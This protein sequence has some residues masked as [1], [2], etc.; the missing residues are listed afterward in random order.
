M[1]PYIQKCQKFSN[2]KFAFCRNHGKLYLKI[3][4][5]NFQI[6]C[7]KCIEEGKISEI[8]IKNNLN[9]DEQINFNCFQHPNKKGSF[10]CDDCKEFICKKCFADFHKEHKCHLPEIIKNEFISYIN[11]EINNTNNLRP[12]L[13]DSINDIKKIHGNLKNRK[14]IL[15]NKNNKFELCGFHKKSIELLKEINNFIISSKNFINI[16]LNDTILKYNENHEKIENSLNSMSKDISKFE[17][18]CFLQ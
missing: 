3:N 11:E 12:M 7:E 10:Y 14:M 8:E 2:I 18:S 4:P 6:V 17:K 1:K 9:E 13:D 16:R 5:S 15:K